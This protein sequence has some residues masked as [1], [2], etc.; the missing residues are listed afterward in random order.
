MQ[1]IGAILPLSSF[2]L[3]CDLCD[4]DAT[5]SH[6]SARVHTDHRDIS[7]LAWLFILVTN[8]SSPAF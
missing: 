3:V 1:V 6:V 8:D 5:K 2:V 7:N 4:P